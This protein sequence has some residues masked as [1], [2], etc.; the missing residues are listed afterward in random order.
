MKYEDILALE[1]ATNEKY[2]ETSQREKKRLDVVREVTALPR[3]SQLH[4]TQANVGPSEATTRLIGRVAID[5]DDP[6]LGKTFYIG[7]SRVDDGDLQVI[8]WSSPMAQIFYKGTKSQTDLTSAYQARRTFDGTIT[9]IVAFEDEV[10]RGITHDPFEIQI[11]TQPTIAAPPT[12][13]Q[14][15]KVTNS[16]AP[17]S[18]AENLKSDRVEDTKDKA[19]NVSSSTSTTNPE[20]VY[21][22]R[23]P[24]EPDVEKRGSFG[25]RVVKMLR[26][27]KTV[28]SQVMAPRTG[29]LK[30]LL[31]T[32]QP[33]QY[34]LVTWNEESNLVIQGHP[35]T[36]KTVIATHRAAYLTSSDRLEKGQRLPPGDVLILG[37]TENYVDHIRPVVDELSRRGVAIWSIAQFYSALSGIKDIRDSA[38]KASLA[39]SLPQLSEYVITSFDTW[40]RERSENQLREFIDY[41]RSE[42]RLTGLRDIE[43]EH[44][45]KVFIREMKSYD[46][47]CRT[48]KYFPLLA[49]CGLLLSN[50]EIA[51]RFRH[52]IVDEAQD[53]STMDLYILRVLSSH[54]LQFSL[55]GDINQR[56]SDYTYDN[57]DEI[58]HVIEPNTQES[59]FVIKKIEIGYR[60]T[61]QI[62]DFAGTLLPK[63]ERNAETLRE[64]PDPI[65]I[66][67]SEQYLLKTAIEIAQQLS[68]RLGGL[69][70]VI[71][72]E[73]ISVTDYCRTLHWRRGGT[74]HS[75][76]PANAQNEIIILHPDLARGLE[77]DGVVVIQPSDFPFTLGRHGVLYTS[78]TRATKELAVVHSTP[79]PLGL[80]AK[81]KK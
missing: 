11:K 79:L 74:F 8:N 17:S 24:L 4:G 37:P 56:R 29:K 33:D 50:A 27:P 46:H 71:T 26:A 21:T 22:T 81:I 55:V 43:F 66:K 65:I 19:P 47:A 48:T 64:G 13:V 39:I 40:R 73:P 69:T 18:Q 58:M 12:P 6:I 2:L 76:I 16:V 61:K 25:S 31:S 35:G 9:E 54:G 32:L 34:D 70:A 52:I 78:L 20:I 77:F 67:V 63:N 68:K 62:L 1:Q 51:N 5:I 14:R 10:E 42:D 72:M 75:W 45:I 60:S 53:L 28:L 15:P 3:N 36:G 59:S 23:D 30:S 41:L 44:D 57:W 49:L 7:S 38:I 80:K